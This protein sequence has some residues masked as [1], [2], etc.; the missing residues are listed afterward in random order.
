[1]EFSVQKNKQLLSIRD[2]SLQRLARFSGKRES[3]VQHCYLFR[4]DRLAGVRYRVGAFIASWFCGDSIISIHRGTSL[5]DQ[6]PIESGIQKA[7]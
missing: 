2:A 5:V 7:A 4:D 1:M 3:D 6:F